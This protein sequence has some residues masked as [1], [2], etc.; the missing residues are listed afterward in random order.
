[1]TR[2]HTSHANPIR[3]SSETWKLSALIERSLVMFWHSL[4]M[5]THGESVRSVLTI[6]NRVMDFGSGDSV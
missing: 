1:M 3:T 6:C 4:K 5:F 2:Y